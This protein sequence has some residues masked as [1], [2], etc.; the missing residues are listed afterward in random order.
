LI[1]LRIWDGDGLLLLRWWTFRFY[2]MRGN[3]LIIGEHYKYVLCCV[4]LCCVVLCCQWDC[5]FQK[6]IYYSN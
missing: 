6:A 4:V 5:C 1:W 2:K 3:S